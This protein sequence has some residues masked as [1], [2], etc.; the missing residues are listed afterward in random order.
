MRRHTTSERTVRWRVH[1]PNTVHMGLVHT[2]WGGLR[3]RIPTT[4]WWVG[5]PPAYAISTS[6][7]TPPPK[8]IKN[9]KRQK[10]KRISKNA[11][12]HKT[13]QLVGAENSRRPSGL[14]AEKATG[15]LVAV[16]SCF[17]PEILVCSGKGL[18]RGTTK[19]IGSK[20][21]SGPRP[22][23]IFLQK[24]TF[25]AR[26]IFRKI[27]DRITLGDGASRPKMPNTTSF[28]SLRSGITKVGW[29]IFGRGP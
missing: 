23:K 26:G 11:K 24:N 18:V 14:V 8:I 10:C 6:P 27:F 25:D 22:R 13:R 21:N 17:A 4:H 20:P 15:G 16:W 1:T 12:K 3:S 2:G 7:R 9:Q 28:A 29:H 5:V 19:K